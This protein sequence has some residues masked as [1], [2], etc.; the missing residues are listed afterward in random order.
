MNTLQKAVTGIGISAAIGL[1]AYAA[2]QVFNESLPPAQVHERLVECD[3]LKDQMLRNK[4]SAEAQGINFDTLDVMQVGSL[5]G[6]IGTSYLAFRSLYREADG[7]KQVGVETV[8][9]PSRLLVKEFV[10]REPDAEMSSG[11]L[12]VRSYQATCTPALV[13]GLFTAMQADAATFE[14]PIT[15]ERSD[16]EIV[17]YGGDTHRGTFGAEVTIPA[18]H[19]IPDT[20]TRIAATEKTL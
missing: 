7:Q 20:Y 3:T 13:D 12:A 15:L 8:P 17:K 18:G 9:V 5:L 2:E 1:S 16:V 11:R 10:P 14:P 4:C 6:L 19:I